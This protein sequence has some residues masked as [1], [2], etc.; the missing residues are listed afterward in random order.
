M[1]FKLQSECLTLSKTFYSFTFPAFLHFGNGSSLM[2]YNEGGNAVSQRACLLKKAIRALFQELVLDTRRGRTSAP[3][4]SQA[5]R[6]HVDMEGSLPFPLRGKDLPENE[7]VTK[8]SGGKEREGD[9]AQ[10][11]ISVF[12]KHII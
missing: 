2:Q 12:L 7:N 8:E 6:C 5:L 1:S 4:R 10:R 9:I 3:L 11:Y